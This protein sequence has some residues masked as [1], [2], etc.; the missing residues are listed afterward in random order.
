ME[1]ILLINAHQSHEGIARGELNQTLLDTAR[2]ALGS[3]GYVLNFREG[4]RI[5]RKNGRDIFFSTD[6]PG[7][8]ATILK[9]SLS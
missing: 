7:E 1:K 5:S 8:L 2:D 9:K 3:I 6:N 4:I